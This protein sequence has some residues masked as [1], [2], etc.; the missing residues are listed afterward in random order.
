MKKEKLNGEFILENA[1]IITACKDLGD[2]GLALGAFKMSMEANLGASIED[3]E[4]A[5]YFGEGQGRYLVSMPT[6]E[7]TLLC[8]RASSTGVEARIIGSFGGESIKLGNFSANL[9][10]L[11]I[12]YTTSLPKALE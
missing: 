8:N 12:C 10:E 1:D 4:I 9:E 7:A 11:K 6:S 3:Q 5:W 2:G